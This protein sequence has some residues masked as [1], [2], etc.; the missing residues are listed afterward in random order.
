MSDT[1]EVIGGDGLG[2]VVNDTR[3]LISIETPEQIKDI[4]KLALTTKAALFY[5]FTEQVKMQGINDPKFNPQD[6]VQLGEVMDPV[7]LLLLSDRGR[8]YIE[9][10]LPHYMD[11]VKKKYEF[12]KEKYT[13]DKVQLTF[14]GFINRSAA[15]AASDFLRNVLDIFNYEDIRENLVKLYGDEDSVPLIFEAYNQN[16]TQNT[17]YVLGLLAV[18]D[19]LVLAKEFRKLA[20]EQFGERNKPDEYRVPEEILYVLNYIGFIDG[21]DTLLDV[22]IKIKKRLKTVLE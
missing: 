20:R 6:R 17:D 1:A 13:T 8:A 9:S 14:A 5:I 7:N 19:Y 22:K 2:D 15:Q 11:L 12:Y 16:E 3:K 4:N 21:K 10:V 18:A